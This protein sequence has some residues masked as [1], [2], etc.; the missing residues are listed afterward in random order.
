MHLLNRGFADCFIDDGNIQDQTNTSSH[1]PVNQDVTADLNNHDAVT[2]TDDTTLS[3]GEDDEEDGWD[4]NPAA[5][6]TLIRNIISGTIHHG[7]TRDEEEA[8]KQAEIFLKLLEQAKKELYPGCKNATKVS[9]IV[10]LFQIKCMYGLSNAAL[11][12]ILKLF[13][14]VLPEGHCIPDSL[15]KVQR[16]VRDLGLDYCDA[17]GF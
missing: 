2:T 1:G 6:N 11:E 3:F 15:Y 9:F 14:K 10:E 13:G 16:V 5:T 12:A 7:Q 17:P 8:D 4:V